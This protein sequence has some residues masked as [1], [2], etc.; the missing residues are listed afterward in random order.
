MVLTLEG[1]VGVVSSLGWKMMDG[2]VWS[3]PP[4]NNPES[5]EGFVTATRPRAMHR[6]LPRARFDIRL[7]AT[8]GKDFLPED[9][10]I[11]AIN[12]CHPIH[13]RPYSPYLWTTTS[14][15]WSQ[16]FTSTTNH[17]AISS[18]IGFHGVHRV[19]S[20]HVA[21][22]QQYH[23]HDGGG[24]CDNIFF[25]VVVVVI[26]ILDITTKGRRFT[27]CFFYYYDKDDD[28]FFLQQ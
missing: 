3:W 7:S 11:T 19:V 13:I 9:L 22:W 20:N 16:H 27:N 2:R 18:W 10:I 5:K 21:A 4:I 12:L 6:A 24:G 28:W 14:C 25:F 8:K 23:W 1:C 15:L 26:A 17:E